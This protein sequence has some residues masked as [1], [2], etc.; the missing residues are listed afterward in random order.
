MSREQRNAASPYRPRQ[1]SCFECVR[2]KRRCNRETHP[3]TWC[4]KKRLECVR[5]FSMSPPFWIVC[6]VSVQDT[7]T[8]SSLQVYP[9]QYSGETLGETSK[10]AARRPSITFTHSCW[11]SSLTTSSFTHGSVP[12]SACMASASSEQRQVNSP[13]RPAR[14]LSPLEQPPQPPPE[15]PGQPLTSTPSPLLPP[16][17]PIPYPIYTERNTF[18]VPNGGGA[19]VPS[20]SL[21]PLDTRHPN[22]Q[23]G[24]FL[25]AQ[26]QHTVERTVPPTNTTPWFEPHLL[27]NLSP[28]TAAAPAFTAGMHY[29]SPVCWAP[30]HLCPSAS[31]THTS[32]STASPEERTFFHA[33]LEAHVASEPHLIEMEQSGP[34]FQQDPPSTSPIILPARSEAVS[35]N[36]SAEPVAS[37]TQEPGDLSWLATPVI[38][39][40]RQ[41]SAP[42]AAIHQ[43][44]R[45]RIAP[46][47]TTFT[48]NAA[49]NADEL[50]SLPR[51]IGE[52]FI[53]LSHPP[54]D[55]M[56]LDHPPPPDPGIARCITASLSPNPPAPLVPQGQAPS[57]RDP[58]VDGTAAVA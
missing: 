38:P 15:P 33:S 43:A 19:I 10:S 56:T 31:G 3:C 2:S 40:P 1:T 4:A 21:L 32:L 48:F 6:N 39:S 54:P 52:D 25:N 23:T 34:I 47:N 51:F 7:D 20:D 12:N 50:R 45:T 37:V 49:N 30:S 57:E 36:P 14:I 53:R 28:S 44:L 11:T 22:N 16:V 46:L 29:S 41:R 18:P 27:S 42:F 58:S 9:A 5:V 17:P 24:V 13:A 35:R 8:C 55:F 26:G